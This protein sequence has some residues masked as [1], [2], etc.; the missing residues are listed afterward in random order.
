MNDFKMKIK[1]VHLS[2]VHPAQD[3]RIFNKECRALK[4]SG[5]EVVVIAQ[6]QEDMHVEGILIRALKKASSRFARMTFLLWKLYRKA[7]KEKADIYHFHD[8]ELIPIGILLRCHGKKVIYDIHEDVPRDILLKEWL[9]KPLRFIVSKL[10]EKFEN[11][12]S[13]FFHAVVTVTP[14]ITQRFERLHAIEIRNYPNISEL[15]NID[16]SQGTYLTYTGLITAARGFHEMVDVASKVSANTL[17][18]AGHFGSQQL[19]GT[20]N[21]SPHKNVQYLGYLAR[22]QLREL[23]TKSLVGLALLH[24]GPTFD[25]SLPIKL[26]EYMSAGIPVIAT[27]FSLWRDIIEKHNCGFCVDPFDTHDIVEKILYLKNNPEERKAMGL[28]GKRAVEKYYNWETESKKL[29]LLYQSI[30][31]TTHPLK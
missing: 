14:H 7:L 26:F 9:P 3:I 12:C 28:R 30:L 25:T 23:Y 1:V 21:A 29:I 11:F 19:A 15:G 6:A 27:H 24:P 17:M 5:Y 4:D 18:L 2:S 22:A 10:F 13:G 20:F 16:S 8:P 31:V